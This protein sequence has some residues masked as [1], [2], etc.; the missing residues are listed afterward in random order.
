MSRLLALNSAHL[1]RFMFQSNGL[2]LST[3]NSPLFYH[4]LLRMMP[5]HARPM[6]P[7]YPNASPA[8]CSPLSTAPMTC[9]YRFKFESS[10]RSALDSRISDVAPSPACSKCDSG[11]RSANVTTINGKKVGGGTDGVRLTRSEVN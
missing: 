7:K 1:T 3:T 2:H 6:N 4:P 9:S 5:A 11:P 8:V 10:D